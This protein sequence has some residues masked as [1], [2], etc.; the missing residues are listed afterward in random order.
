MLVGR[1]AERE[2][3][4]RLL[5]GARAGR[6]GALVIRG[7]AGIGKTALLDHARGLAAADFRI[8]TCAGVESETPLAFAALHQLCLPLIDGIN[9]LPD[10]QRDALE[11]VFGTRTARAPD[12]FLVALATLSLLTD[13]AES[14]PLLCCVDDAQWIDDASARVIAFVARRLEQDRVAVLVAIRDLG[15]DELH[16]GAGA[17]VWDGALEL[18]LT[19]LGDAEAQSLLEREL[20]L[21]LAESLRDRIIAEAGGNPLAL[22]EFSRRA[23]L[24]ELAGG[25]ESP[26]LIAVPRRIEESYRQRSAGLA[27]DA[28]LFLLLAAADATGDAVL[29]WQAAE[30]LGLGR[31]SVEPAVDAGLLKVDTRVRFRHP[32]VRSAVYRTAVPADRRRVHRALAA[33]TDPR[34]DPDRHAW[35]CAAGVVKADESVADAL[36]RSAARTTARGGTAA[37]AELLQRSAELTPDPGVRSRRALAAAQAKHDAG[38]SRVAR[39]LLTVAELGPLDAFRRA[40]VDLLRAQIAFHLAPGPEAPELLLASAERLSPLDPGLSRET[41][42]QALDAALVTDPARVAR[43]AKAARA[44]PPPPGEPSAADLLLDALITTFAEGYSAGSVPVRRAMAAFRDR[45]FTDAGTADPRER[46][47]LWLATRTAVAFFDDETGFLLAERNAHLGREAGALSTLPFAL[48][49]LASAQ[50]LAGDLARSAETSAEEAAITLATGIAPQRYGMLFAA[51]WG[52]NE[53]ETKRLFRASME[54]AGER[55]A[56]AGTAHYALAVL[57]NGLGRYES[58]REAAGTSLETGELVNG[59]LTLPELVEAGVRAGDLAAARV[60]EAELSVRAA[61]SGTPMA[62]GLAARSRALL[63]GGADAERDHREAIERL[64]ETR[65]VGH[66]GRAYLVYGEWLRREGRRQV[67]REQLHTAHEL[68]SGAGA[69]AFAARAGR[70]LRATGARPRRRTEGPADALTPQEQ[71]IAGLVASGATSRE[72]GAQLFLSSRTIDAHLRSIYRKLGINSRRQLPDV[73]VR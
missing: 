73:L 4:E 41:Y 49:A 68:L 14:G 30:R 40:R 59:S 16:E 60:A 15:R 25:F 72:V 48:G 20:S 10:S 43:V 9:T 55:R 22:V 23:P 1:H 2:A 46:R 69:A 70:E 42:L 39:E 52:G 7:Q 35:H 19:G 66:L 26:G 18:P 57:Y 24:A 27:A 56:E 11:T 3:I 44:A 45:G 61:A 51:A 47:W 31:E 33:V 34:T 36:E 32:L 54:N 29:L 37:A 13:A 6:S 38:A 71:L 65:M 62:Q 53:S 17:S 12:L 28:Q 64:S 50:A 5:D 21:P 8:V 63:A 58:A 67:A